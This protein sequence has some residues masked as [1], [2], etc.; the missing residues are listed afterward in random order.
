MTFYQKRSTV[1]FL[2]RRRELNMSFTLNLVALTSL[3]A[4]LYD[5]VIVF[6]MILKTSPNLVWRD[7]PMESL[8][9]S[10][11][12][13][14]LFA[15]LASLVV[16]S[17]QSISAVCAVLPA[18]VWSPMV[19]EGLSGSK[20][21]CPE[22]D[23]RFLPVKYFCPAASAWAWPGQT[24]GQDGRAAGTWQVAPW[25]VACTWLWCLA[26]SAAIFI[27][28][29]LIAENWENWSYI[30]KILENKNLGPYVENNKN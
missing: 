2:G 9:A 25:G 11:F 21:A 10:I 1:P 4:W 17:L 5:S 30:N 14:N 3:F 15:D 29:S 13:L 12:G 7:I 16:F 8:Y 27:S 18:H 28:A 23:R 6:F 20:Q 26:R 24:M 19:Q 22:A